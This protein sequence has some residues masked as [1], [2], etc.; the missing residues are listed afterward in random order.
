MVCNPLQL[1]IIE[2]VIN[3]MEYE[4][5]LFVFIW[6]EIFDINALFEVYI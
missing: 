4:I 2:I 3:P 1:I 6:T 5:L